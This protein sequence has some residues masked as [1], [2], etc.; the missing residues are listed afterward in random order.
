MI[1]NL[2]YADDTVIIA[3]SNAELQQL[4]NIVVQETKNG[5]YLNSTVNFFKWYSTCSN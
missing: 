3:V 5:L 4:L 2:T 1:N